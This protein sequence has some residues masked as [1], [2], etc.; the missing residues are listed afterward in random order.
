MANL[1]IV[2][3]H[4]VNGVSQLHTDLMRSSVFADFAGLRP[5]AFVNVT[6]GITPRRWLHHANPGLSALITEHIGEGWVTDLRQL[7]RLVPLAEDGAFRA[8]FM[9]AK[10]ANKR[11][12]QALIRDRIGL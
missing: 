7:E 8:R 2:G 3:S 11:R 10:A 12:L 5:E 6:N 4:H 9:A 1:A